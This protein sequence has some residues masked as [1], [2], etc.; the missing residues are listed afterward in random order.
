MQLAVDFPHVDA[1]A[2]APSSR[3]DRRLRPRPRQSWS[4]SSWS[5]RSGR[6]TPGTGR[7]PSTSG[8]GGVLGPDYR[9]V[10]DHGLPG[11]FGQSDCSPRTPSFVR[12]CRPC[13]IVELTEEDANRITQPALV[14]LGE[15]TVAT[16]PER[17]ELLLAWLPNA[18]PFDLSRRDASPASA[19]PA[20]DGR[21]PRL[22]LRA[23]PAHDIVRASNWP[24]S[25]GPLGCRI[26]PPER[27]RDR[28][29]HRYSCKAR[30]RVDV[31]DLSVS[32]QAAG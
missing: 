16:F 30:R 27:M 6:T 19:E 9:V 20:R 13:S 4:G 2:R 5:P 15:N 28:R 1:H 21:R 14:V 24:D 7:L 18:E 32:R 3:R 29:S 22:L 10:L 12:S 8:A 11:A 23:A 17:R 26:D 25:L 31:R